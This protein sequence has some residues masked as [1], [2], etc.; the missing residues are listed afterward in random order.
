MNFI[1][2]STHTDSNMVII[3]IQYIVNLIAVCFF[4]Q[5]TIYIIMLYSELKETFK[6]IYDMDE[7][8]LQN[9][10]S[11]VKAVLFELFHYYFPLVFG[12]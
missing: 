5:M 2:N 6:P 1:F 10:S 11:E 12:E 3:T 9:Q 7:K 8:K 4:Q